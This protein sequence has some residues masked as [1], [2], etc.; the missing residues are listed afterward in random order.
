MTFPRKVNLYEVGPRDGLQ[1]EKEIIP[2]DVKVNLINKLI[3]CNFKEIEIGSF[4]SPKWVP[5]MA[6]SEIII[7]KINKPET[8][9]FP[10]LTPNL[11]GVQ[12]AIEKKADTVC[13]FVTASET[14]SKKNTNCT[15]S[16]SLKRVEEI[17][18]EVKK[19]NIKVRG[20]LSCVLGCPYEGKVSYEST[21]DLASFLIEQGCYQVSLGDTIGCGT[22][23]DA[24]KLFELVSKK[25]NI[26]KIA[27]HFHDTYG[28][29]LSN[30]YAVLQMG[31]QTLDTSVAGLGGCPYAKGATGNVATE[32]VLYMLNGIGIKTG[33]KLEEIIEVSWYISN[34]MKRLPNSKVARAYTNQ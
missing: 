17:I 5:Q 24:I 30:I 27:A 7:D 23:L 33:I 1:N 14:F 3:N 6:D 2:I 16:D 21:A 19:H 9:S 32:D 4:V 15:V 20:Y 13:V 29:A 26:E 25:V 10:V 12:K 18:G 28:Q 22:P 11:K 31:I 34:Y 8:T